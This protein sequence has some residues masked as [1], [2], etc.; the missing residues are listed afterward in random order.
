MICLKS[1]PILS[2][3]SDALSTSTEF[4]YT[5]EIRDTRAE[6]KRLGDKIVWA[7]ERWNELDDLM[8]IRQECQ[9]DFIGKKYCYL[10]ILQAIIASLPEYTSRITLD[11]CGIILMNGFFFSEQDALGYAS[12][13][14]SC[15]VWTTLVSKSP[16]S[17]KAR[18]TSSLGQGTFDGL[19]FRFIHHLK[20]PSA[21][22]IS[23]HTGFSYESLMD[24]CT[25][26]F[27]DSV[28]NAD[29]LSTAATMTSM[30]I[31][32]PSAEMLRCLS[33]REYLMQTATLFRTFRPLKSPEQCP[34]KMRS[35]ALYQLIHSWQRVIAPPVVTAAESVRLSL[36]IQACQAN[37]VC[38]LEWWSL[39]ESDAQSKPI[40]RN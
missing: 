22:W 8:G 40:G 34:A 28:D 3:I 18:R 24:T 37:I 23:Q 9:D 14:L 30:V 17:T 7:C 13:R 4:S 5:I 32:D 11:N 6:W 21:G 36:A 19:I 16:S 35:R 29:M 27:A 12:M 31:S 20:P 26:A 38:L 1:L 2:V 33:E 15:T 39:A 25:K 10:R